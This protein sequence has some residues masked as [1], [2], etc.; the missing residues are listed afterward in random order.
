M[1]GWG[2]RSRYYKGEGGGP[3]LVK[4]KTQKKMWG[5]SRV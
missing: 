4:K 2:G 3:L 1:Q 5:R